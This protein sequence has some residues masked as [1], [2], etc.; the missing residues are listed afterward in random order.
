[1]KKVVIQA[2]HIN[3]QNNSIVELRTSTGAPG[4][5]ELTK[6]IPDRLATVVS[7]PSWRC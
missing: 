5:Q 1:M 2:G 4:E 6:R 3:C 7:S